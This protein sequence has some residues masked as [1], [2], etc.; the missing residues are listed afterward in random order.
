MPHAPKGD[1]IMSKIEL[2]ED[3]VLVLQQ[4]GEEG[5]NDLSLLAESL[6][7]DRKRLLHIVTALQHKGL[8]KLQKVKYDTS[9]ILSAKG[10]RLM[11]YLWPESN[12]GFSY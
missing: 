6:Q 8:V 11:R 7:F 3:Y 4:I 10:R 12:L 1:C 9:I 5:E 2:S